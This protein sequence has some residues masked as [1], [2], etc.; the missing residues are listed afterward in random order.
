MLFEVILLF[1]ECLQKWSLG[2]AGLACFGLCGYPRLLLC[3]DGQL[4][5]PRLGWMGEVSPRGHNSVDWSWQPLVLG[6][7]ALRSCLVL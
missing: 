4:G 2:V 6:A 1:Q 5:S 7:I 3:L